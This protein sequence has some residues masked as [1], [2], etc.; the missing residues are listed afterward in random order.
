MEEKVVKIETY[1]S[2][3]SKAKRRFEDVKDY[4]SEHKEVVIALAP[5]V[6]GGAVEMVKVIARKGNINEEKRLKDNYIYDRSAGHYYE[7][8]RKPKN[9]EWVQ[10]DHRKQLGESLGDIL[11]DMRL[12]K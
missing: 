11:N 4:C 6:I 12:L 10:I 2:W 9:S 7:L 8:R 3:K 5:C 1:G